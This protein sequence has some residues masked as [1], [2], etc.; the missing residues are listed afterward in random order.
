[1]LTIT[2]D[3]SRKSWIYLSKIRDALYDNLVKWRK[4]VELEADLRL[5]AIRI[6]NA[7]ELKKIGELLDVITETTTPY[8]PE[9]NGVA[10]R[11]NRTLITKARSMLAAAELPKELWGEAV[12]TAC[13]LRNLTPQNKESKSPEEIWTGKK[14]SGKHLRVF[15][16]VAYPTIPKERRVDKLDNTAI[17]GVFVGYERSTKHYRIYNPITKSIRLYTSVRF[18]ENSKGGSLLQGEKDI[19]AVTSE[20]PEA[21]FD[22]DDKDISIRN[23]RTNDINDRS[24]DIDDENDDAG[25]NIDVRPRQDNR[26]EAEPLEERPTTTRSGRVT[27]LP[28]RYDNTRLALSTRYDDSVNKLPTPTTYTEAISSIN[29]REWLIAIKEQL[30][31]LIANNTW[32]EVDK[33]KG[34]NLVTPK[35]VFKIKRLPNGQIDK[36][37]ARLVARGFTQQYGID[38]LETFSPVVRLESL[39]IIFAI[40]AAK[41][42]VLHQMDVVSAYLIGE[43]EDEVYLEAPEGIDITDNRCLKLNKGIPGLKQ[44]GRVWNKTIVSFFNSLGLYALPAEPSV[45]TNSR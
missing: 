30:D 21:V 38:Y 34:I 25:S 41:R 20:A 11:L 8:T 44:S 2:D 36:Y 15:G 10:E 32:T 23:D 3:Y 19:Y 37:K 7:K 40:V 9:Q 22:L 6:D 29:R 17:K 14:L 16:C 35:W 43:L 5:K 1:M 4:Q 24:N 13:Y 28:A 18:D 33:P 42:L 39:R 45:F 26:I 31:S 27:R 12:Y